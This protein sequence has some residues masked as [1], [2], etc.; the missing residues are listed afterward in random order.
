MNISEAQ[1]L[2]KEAFNPN[3]YDA[4][5]INTQTKMLLS[6]I[7]G[8]EPHLI[9]IEYGRVL[10]ENQTT[11][12]LS[13]LLDIQNNKPLQYITGKTDFFGFSFLT[14]QGVLIPRPETEE[15]VSLVHNTITNEK[16]SPACI[17]DIGTGSGCI[18]VSLKKLIPDSTI[19]AIDVSDQA[20]E[21]AIENAKNLEAEISFLKKDILSD[22]NFIPDSVNILVSNPPYVLESEKEKMYPNV[23]EWEPELALFVDDNNPLVFYK[24]IIEFGEHNKK[25]KNL[26]FEI[27]PLTVNLFAEILNQN[28]K[29]ES[30]TFHNDFTGKTRFLHIRLNQ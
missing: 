22:E 23:L 10:N 16:I 28:A 18:A 2:I 4:K 21:V 17:C 6:S 15:L 29:I 8:L 3:F 11:I 12:L 27:N 30:Y 25:V 5:E 7:T 9:A 24:R 20:L 14:G 13:A 19:F 26:F 1:K